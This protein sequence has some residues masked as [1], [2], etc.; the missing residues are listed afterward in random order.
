[1]QGGFNMGMGKGMMHGKMGMQMGSPAVSCV[2][3]V[4]FPTA[5]MAQQAIQLTG[6]MV[7]GRQIELRIHAA[8]KDGT[9]LQIMNL[10]AGVE[11]QAVKDLFTQ[12]GLQPLFVETSSD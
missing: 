1:M 6:S 10:P 3:Q 9:K 12:N 8:S 4:R 11:W 5:E 7:S 2:G